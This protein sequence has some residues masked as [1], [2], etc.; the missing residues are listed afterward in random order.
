MLIQSCLNGGRTVEEH[1][2]L[3]RCPAKLAVAAQTPV[4]AGACSLHIHPATRA[5]PSRSR[6]PTWARP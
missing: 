4:A 3:P 6:P 1:P 2:A 5:A